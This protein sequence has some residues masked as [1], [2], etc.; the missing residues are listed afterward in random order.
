M[1]EL[2]TFHFS[3]KDTPLGTPPGPLEVVLSPA[4]L[5]VARMSPYGSLDGPFTS[6]P[7]G[8]LNGSQVME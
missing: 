4:S 2:L 3:P 7:S 8:L 6:F 5:R 1:A